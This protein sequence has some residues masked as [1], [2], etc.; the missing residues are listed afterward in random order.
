M[1][2]TEDMHIAMV[3]YEK[4]HDIVSRIPPE[5]WREIFVHTLPCEQLHHYRRAHMY[6]RPDSSQAPLKL[7]LVCH[8]W[9][10]ISTTCPGLWTSIS[11]NLTEVTRPWIWGRR[12]DTEEFRT[13]QAKIEVGVEQWLSK[14]GRLPLTIRF[15]ELDRT[16]CEFYRLGP[17]SARLRETFISVA[18][19]WRNLEIDGQNDGGELAKVLLTGTRTPLLKSLIFGLGHCVSAHLDLDFSPLQH[20]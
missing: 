3:P 7:G 1:D 4:N 10:H 2:P 15:E 14:S 5:V 17:P 18:S 8:E 11:I 20:P 13:L 12:T 16:S 6:V 9:R 19:R